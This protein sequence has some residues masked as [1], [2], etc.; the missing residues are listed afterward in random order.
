ML[1][2]TAILQLLLIPG[3]DETKPVDCTFS[4]PRYAGSCIEQVTPTG[5]QTPVQACRV[6]LDCLNNSQCVKTYCNATTVRGGWT[7]VEPRQEDNKK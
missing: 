3:L 2:L 5:N 7:L 4:N 6:V 1:I